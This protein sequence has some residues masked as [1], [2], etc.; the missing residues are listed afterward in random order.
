MKKYKVRTLVIMTAVLIMTLPMV[1]SAA[2]TTLNADY[3]S[4]KATLSCSFHLKAFNNDTATATTEIT[5][6]DSAAPTKYRVAVRLEEWE[7][8]KKCTRF[9]YKNG[10]NKVTLTTSV[11]DVVQFASRHS[12]DNENNTKEL[13]VTS[14]YDA[15]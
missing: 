13:E 5:E 15:E 3:A 14:F 2:S 6:L 9:Q 7:T 10:D 1:V 4:A 8:K 12:I 11:E